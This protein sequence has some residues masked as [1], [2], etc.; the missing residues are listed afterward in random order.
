[1]T[2][3]GADRYLSAAFRNK[4]LPER[5]RDLEAMVEAITDCAIIQL[6]ANGDVARWCPGAEAMT[7]Y[8]AAEV[9]GRP[10]ALL[11]TSE[12]RAAGLAEREL[13]AARESGRCEFEGWRTRKNGQRFRAGVA[14]SVFTD[15]AGSAIGFTTVMRDVTAEHQRAETMFHAL[16]ESA[17][18]A[19]VIVGPDGRIVL[20]NAQADQMFGYPREELI[21]REV[22]I[23]IPPRHR[24]SHE[25]YRTGFFAAPAA[26]RMGAGL[27]LWGMRCDG[28]VFPVDV[29]L[30]PLQTEQGVMVSAAIRDIT[31]QLAVQAELTETRAQAEVLAERDRIAGDLQDHAI[32]RV[33]AVGLALQ[34]TIPRAR[35]A[36]VQQRLNAAVDDLHAVVQDFRTAIFDLR[37]TK[38]DVPGLRQRFD[39][40]IGRLAEGLAT[41]VQYKG[42]LSVVEGELADQA[43]AVVAEAIGNAV[44]HTA[45]TKLTIAVEVAD[46]V[47][48]EVIDNGKGLP[49]DVSEAG[50]KM[51]RRRAERVGGTLTVG[52]PRAGAPD[53]AGWLRCP[54]RCCVSAAAQPWS[55]IACHMYG[56]H[57][58]RSG[59]RDDGRNAVAERLAGKVALVSGGARG[60]GASH[61]RSLVAEGAKVVFGDILDDEGKAVAAE[62][63]EAT[64]YLHLDVTK[65]EDWDAAVA[66]ALAEFGR[67]DVLVNNAG[68]INI[69]TLEDYALSEWQRILDINL[70]GVF[71]GIRAVVK[72]MKEAGRG[73]I[74]NISSIEGMAGTIACHGYTATKFAVRGLT[75]SAALELGPSGIRVNS[76]HPGLIKTPMTE[77]V[78]EDI[79][80]SALGRAAEPKE[81]SNLVVYLA[82]DESSYSTGS[83][84]VVDGGTTA[85]LG[86]KDFSNVETDAQPDW[87][88]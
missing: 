55:Y 22:E 15:D 67:I 9:L 33:F 48:I 16:L 12:D 10:A 34:G 54:D 23:L 86:H 28:T 61:V 13:A 78:P 74:I 36:D 24:G 2:S 70:T 8:S 32:Q 79:F 41:T 63:G 66:T 31:E 76:I 14:L 46:E 83:E 69:G 72:P 58:C 82:S 60:M 47:S 27:E 38:T 25:R 5:L 77:W 7:G 64:R 88:T 43:E 50:L 49:D 37:H 1:M 17:P 29:S 42:P 35:S 19:M 40:V 52:A 56:A 21:G 3:P 65:P 71:L 11:Y 84:F 87:V 73:S 81:V 53:C 39:E 20:A 80:Q 26:R 6:D 30:S 45:A 59:H 62:V 75:K 44:R 85:G 68:I 57:T 18:D 51:L 4:S